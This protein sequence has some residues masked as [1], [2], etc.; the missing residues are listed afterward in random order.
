MKLRPLALWRIAATLLWIASIV[1]LMKAV[2]D[3][4]T[5]E[6]ALSNPHLNDLDRIAIQHL[7]R[8]ADIWAVVGWGLQLVTAVVLSAG[9]DSQ[10]AVRRVF[11]SLGIL[12]A[13][14]G[15]LLL[16]VAVLVR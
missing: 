8:V 1:C 9:I 12:I 6:E 5:A 13:A 7:G 4:A 15:I 2:G 16:L 3:A 11:A 14:D 10:R